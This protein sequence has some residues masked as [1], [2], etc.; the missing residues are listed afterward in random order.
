M[1]GLYGNIFKDNKKIHTEEISHL[2]YLNLLKKNEKVSP[3]DYLKNSLEQVVEELKSKNPINIVKDIV[4]SLKEKKDDKKY[5]L[6]QLK[7]DWIS[8]DG[9]IKT[10]I[11]NIIK[12]IKDD[13]IIIEGNTVDMLLL[14]KKSE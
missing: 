5:S 3:L 6:R 2:I 11:F 14:Q 4:D 10:D 9:K 7:E 1:G 8:L 13:S 12:E